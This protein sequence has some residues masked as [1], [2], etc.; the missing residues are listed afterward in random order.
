M[1]DLKKERVHRSLKNELDVL[2]KIG[3]LNSPK[4]LNLIDLI[5]VKGYRGLVL[6]RG[7][8]FHQNG[9]SSLDKI[10]GF[11]FFCIYLNAKFL[12]V[13]RENI[14]FSISFLFF[15]FYLFP[16]ISIS[17]TFLFLF[18]LKKSPS[19]S[20]QIESLHAGLLEV[21]QRLKLIHGDI[22]AHN[23][24][25]VRNQAYLID[26]EMAKEIG[27]SSHYEGTSKFSSLELLKAREER[28]KHTYQ[29]RDDLESLFSILVYW[30]NGKAHPFDESN[31]TKK[32]AFLDRWETTLHS[33]MSTR[34]IWRADSSEAQTTKFN[35]IWSKL[36][37]DYNPQTE[38]TS[39]FE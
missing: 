8:P 39:L 2:I 5:K 10:F 37:Q 7:T 18:F 12:K 25:F 24:V 27:A 34:V 30:A 14:F 17:I 29:A 21:H 3:E 22:S 35:R 19:F 23:I 16:F 31:F 36:Y 20:R 28:R 32:T 9:I 11:F 38:V 15:Y 26:W 33:I 13:R 1:S 6:P 4:F